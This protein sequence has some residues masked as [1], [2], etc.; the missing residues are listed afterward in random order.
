M[1]RVNEQGAALASFFFGALDSHFLD[2]RT[3]F[4]IGFGLFCLSVASF[5]VNEYIDARDTDMY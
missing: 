4:I 3:L 2:L 1:L 5:V